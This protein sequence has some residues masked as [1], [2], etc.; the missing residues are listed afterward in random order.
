MASPQHRQI[1]TTWSYDTTAARTL[2][3]ASGVIR[4]ATT[5]NVQVLALEVCR[6]YG[7]TLGMCPSVIR[8]VELL[9]KVKYRSHVIE[10]LAKAYIGW[11]GGDCADELAS[12]DWGCWSSYPLLQ[13]TY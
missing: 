2:D 5:D 3:I 6:R 7:A 11:S 1:T 12:S 10:H 9:A 13:N 8:T 4:A